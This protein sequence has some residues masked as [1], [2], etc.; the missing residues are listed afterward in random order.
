[1]TVTDRKTNGSRVFRSQITGRLKELLTARCVGLLQVD[2]CGS[3][4]YILGTDDL[5]VT[6]ETAS[7]LTSKTFEISHENVHFPLKTAI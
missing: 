2:I 6:I 7:S 1:M 3:G 4:T 5:P